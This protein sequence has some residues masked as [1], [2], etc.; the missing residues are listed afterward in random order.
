MSR[1]A[2]LSFFDSEL[3]NIF[4]TLPQ[5]EK[6]SVD[7]HRWRNDGFVLA[8]N[9]VSEENT[10]IIIFYDCQSMSAFTKWTLQQQVFDFLWDK[11]G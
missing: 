7:I 9:L 2:T 5:T 3:G 11:S 4:K 10:D 1:N 6:V 8:I